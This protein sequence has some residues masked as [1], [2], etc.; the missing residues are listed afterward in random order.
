M[1]LQDVI[2]ELGLEHLTSEQQENVLEELN[3]RVGEKLFSQLSEEQAR[4][5]EAILNGDQAVIDAWLQANAPNYKESEA[6]KEFSIGFEE[7]PDKVPADKVF[8]SMAWVQINSPNIDAT[9]DEIKAQLKAEFAP[10]A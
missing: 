8:A 4:E 1:D 5:Y 10:A 7:D 3:R 6:Y 2:V 9:V